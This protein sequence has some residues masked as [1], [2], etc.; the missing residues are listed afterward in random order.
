MGKK[1]LTWV[2]VFDTII[3]AVDAGGTLGEISKWS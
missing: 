2:Y 1:W 3:F